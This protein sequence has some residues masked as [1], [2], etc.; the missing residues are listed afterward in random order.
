[1]ASDYDA[2]RSKIDALVEAWKTDCLVESGSLL[3]D[4]RAIWTIPNLQDFRQRFLENPLLGTEENF[5][6]K[7]TT[8]L[9]TASEDVRWLVCELI[10]VY[11]L[12]AVGAIGGPAKRATLEAIIAP[13]GE[14]R[15][16]HWE[17]LAET[18]DEGIGNPGLGY[19]VRR[20][21]QIGYL[22]GLLPPIQSDRRSG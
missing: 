8:Q 10:A 1:M 22:H 12:F 3:F 20:D 17:G 5:G 13:L 7:L 19:N 2:G 21:L 14:E 15:P 4:D 18:M 9:E 16:P 6:Q 11:F